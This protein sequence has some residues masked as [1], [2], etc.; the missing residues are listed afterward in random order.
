MPLPDS[1][2]CF[3]ARQRERLRADRSKKKIVFP[4]GDDPRVQAAAAQLAGEDLL[5]PILVV[6]KPAQ[7][8][9]GVHC[10]VPA[11]SPLLDKYARLL[12]ER[13]RARGLSELEAREQAAH[14]LYFAAL[15]VSA[16]DAD[17]EVASA[18]HTTPESVRAILHAI[19]MRPGFSRLSSA[20]I[21]AVHNRSYGC[22]GLLVFADAAIVIQP[23]ALELAEI[24]IAAAETTRTLLET[25]PLVALL[26]FSTK[27]SARHREVDKVVEALRYLRARVPELEV[28]GELQADA[29]L[30]PAVGRSKAPGSLVAGRANTLVFPDLNSANIGYKLVER[31]GD[32]A[33]LAVILQGISRPANIVSR[34]CSSEDIVHAAI[35][36]AVEAAGSEEAVSRG[37]Q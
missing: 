27:G 13:R 21:M 1:A 33:L 6:A 22:D 10:I 2:A 26:S 35:L 16:G 7:A 8:P 17:G 24:A 31:L 29:A 28:D 30:L 34:G 9:A 12:W 14:P 36:T 23:S 18:V 37:G 4:E 25:E 32:A 3:M 11:E 15:M 20:H 19:D 5:Q